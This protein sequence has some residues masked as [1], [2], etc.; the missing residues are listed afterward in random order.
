MPKETATKKSGSFS[1]TEVTKKIVKKE[2][3][4]VKN[5]EIKVLKDSQIGSILKNATDMLSTLFNEHNIPES[6]D[7][8]HCLKVQGHM[9]QCVKPNNHSLKQ[10]ISQERK[11]ALFLA[12]LLHEAD[13]SKYFEGGNKNAKIIAKKSIP[14]IAN[15]K[16]I[17]KEV[18]EMIDYVST[19]ANG[20]K[21]PERA[22]EE[23]E[24]LWVRFCDRLEAVGKIGV[25]RC[26]QF[27]KEKNTAM[28]NAT[29]P[30]PKT[31]KEVWSFATKDRL[32]KYTEVGTSTSMIDHYYDKLLHIVETDTNVTKNSFLANM[33]KKMAYP[34]VNVCLEYGKTGQVPE[35]LIKKYALECGFIY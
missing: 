27:T 3:D 9:R 10:P 16:T 20:K 30:R 22:K 18:L 6:H 35:W 12:A 32:K 11:L 24:F 5:D 21:I 15:R 2:K 14:E 34:L 23:P 29:S 31:E 13:D 28:N 25:V 19:S 17:I 33:A 4:T 1:K 8:A 7:V 26:W